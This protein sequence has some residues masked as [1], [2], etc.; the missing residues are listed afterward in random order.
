[1]P[2]GGAASVAGAPAR[3]VRTRKKIRSRAVMS[4]DHTS[5]EIGRDPAITGVGS[6]EFIDLSLAEAPE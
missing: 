3:S 6:Q 4:I 5:R 1:V 2:S